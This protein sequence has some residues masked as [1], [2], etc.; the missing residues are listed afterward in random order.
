MALMLTKVEI[1]GVDVS[2]YVSSYNFQREKSNAIGM[3]KL[4]LG[5]AVENVLVI[6]NNQTVDIW[7]GW[8]TSTDEKIFSGNI[9]KWEKQGGRIDI[10]SKDKLWQLVRKEV[11]Y[12]YDSN[13]DASAGKLSEIFKD[14]VTTWGSLTADSISVQDSGTEVTISRFVCRHT[15]IFAN[16]KR[17]ANY[18]K[19]QF[20]YDASTD[21]VYFEPEG[22]TNNSIIIDYNY[23]VEVPK[24]KFDMTEMVNRIDIIGAEQLVGHTLTASGT[25]SQTEYNI[26]NKDGNAVKPASIKVTLDSIVQ[27]GGLEDSTKN[28]EY[29]VD[30][31]EKTYTFTTA[32]SNSAAISTDIL[33]AVPTPV[34]WKNQTSID[35]YGL[36][37]KTIF[38]TDIK[39]VVDAEV[40][41]KSEIKKYSLPFVSTMLKLQKLQTGLFDVGQTVS[42]HDV[43][44]NMTRSVTINKYVIN[45]PQNFDKAYVGDKEWRTGDFEATVMEKL[46]RIEEQMMENQDILLQ[47]FDSDSYINMV[48]WGRALLQRD[49]DSTVLIWNHPLYGSW[50][51]QN[52]GSSSATGAYHVKFCSGALYDI[53]GYDMVHYDRRIEEAD[54]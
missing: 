30:K 46:H 21:K 7:R 43:K 51:T 49:V 41:A 54:S 5:Q 13:I 24:W 36:C 52:W 33:Y 15:D 40:Q 6:D 16:C 37:E 26:T 17:L 32:P 45:Y 35:S 53:A 28:P 18:L 10:T 48:P 20:Y 44:N 31:E 50:G 47:I 23:M 11:T 4:I 14:L 19:W 8:T 3:T 29:T 22:Y 2:S 9:E 25:G 42:V 39:N 1:N 34:R 27:K 38:Y 12:S